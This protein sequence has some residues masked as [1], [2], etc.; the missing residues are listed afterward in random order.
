MYQ[1]TLGMR[2]IK[3]KKKKKK[4]YD[5]GTRRVVLHPH[6]PHERKQRSPFLKTTL[7]QMAAF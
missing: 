4:K 7:L 5:H 6:K 2:V 3:K 1:S